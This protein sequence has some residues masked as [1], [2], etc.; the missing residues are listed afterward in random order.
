MADVEVL[1]PA[2]KFSLAKERVLQKLGAHEKSKDQTYYE[3]KEKIAKLEG[4]GADISSILDLWFKKICELSSASISLSKV[5]MRVYEGTNERMESVARAYCQEQETIK[6]SKI[7]KLAERIE[8]F[9]K[10]INNY[11]TGVDSTRVAMESRRKLQLSYDHYNSKCLKLQ[12]QQQKNRLSGKLETLK[13][14]EKF[15]RNTQKLSSAKSAFLQANQT[16]IKSM[17]HHWES[18]FGFLDNL[19]KQVIL[20]ETMFFQAL[21]KALSSTKPLLSEALKKPLPKP[22]PPPSQQEMNELNDQVKYGNQTQFGSAE[23]NENSISGLLMEGNQAGESFNPAPS[24]A[25]RARSSS[26][27]TIIGKATPDIKFGALMGKAKNLFSKKRNDGSLAFVNATDLSFT[28]QD[29]ALE[30]KATQSGVEHGAQQQQPEIDQKDPF[31]MFDST[32]ERGESSTVNQTVQSNPFS[33]PQARTVVQDDPWNMTSQKQENPFDVAGQSQDPFSVQGT[34]TVDP[35]AEMTTT[36]NPFAGENN[37][38]DFSAGKSSPSPDPFASF[39][40]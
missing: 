40:S 15:E 21:G 16:V 9:T 20:N 14:R 10:E 8:M 28:G 18:R 23:N 1:S 29:N 6:N 3:S 33:K 31:S 25:E 34:R 11:M 24:L 36:P 39:F 32:Q 12:A 2:S 17:H 7:P 22:A 37:A 13:Q 4:I 35:F 5:W 30:E 19:F 38:G 26:V 27:G